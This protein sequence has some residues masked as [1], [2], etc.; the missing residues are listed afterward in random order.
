MPK[1]KDHE[2]TALPFLRVINRF[3]RRR[4][5]RLARRPTGTFLKGAKEP[6]RH[7]MRAE[8]DESDA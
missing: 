2:L 4:L 3:R 7:H 5:Q 6:D 8:D 1:D